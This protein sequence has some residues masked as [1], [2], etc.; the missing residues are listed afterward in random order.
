MTPEQI[1]LVQRSLP[2][3]LAIRDRATAR[4]GERLAVLDRAP[5]RLFAGAD[6]GRQGAVL[7]NAVTAAMQ[8]L[9]SGDYGSVLAALSQ[10]HLSYG[11][12]PQH[13]RSAGAALARALEQE[14]GS[15]FTADLGHAWA[16]AC[17]WV[18]RVIL[19]ESHPMAA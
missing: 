3:I 9:R 5:G 4:T 11:I 8:A 13:F 18:G 7:I 16:A 2:A 19:A 15:S 1:N 17:E 10:Y 12:G 6:I 14:L